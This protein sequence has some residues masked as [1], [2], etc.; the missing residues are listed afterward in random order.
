MSFALELVIGTSTDTEYLV[1]G[2]VNLYDSLDSRTALSFQLLIPASDNLPSVGQPVYLASSTSGST[3]YVFGG[4]LDSYTK[5]IVNPHVSSS[6]RYLH[7]N[8]QCVDF[9]QMIGKRLVYKNYPSSGLGDYES[10]PTTDT[11]TGDGSNRV[12]ELTY[13]LTTDPT[14][15]IDAIPASVG[16]YGVA[17]STKAFY[18]TPSSHILLSNTSN[19]AMATTD[20]LKA[21]YTGIKGIPAYDYQIIADIGAAFCDGEGI[22]FATYVSTGQQLEEL[23]CNFTPANV[24]INTI[25]N[26]TGRSWYIDPWKNLHYFARSENYSPWD[27][28]STSD[29][30]RSLTVR[31]SRDKYRNKEYVL[32]SYGMNP[33]EESFY[34]DG[35]NRTFTLSHAVYA[36]PVISINGYAASVGVLNVA[37]STK[38][39]YWMKESA[40]IVQN[41][42]NTA[43]AS[44][45]T[46]KVSYIGLYPVVAIAEDGAEIAARAAIEGNSGKYEA[47]TESN[48]TYTGLAANQYGASI[49]S[50][51]GRLLDTISFET[52]ESGLMAG[53]LIHISLTDYDIDDDYYITQVTARDVGMATLRYSVQAVSGSDRGG[54]VSFFRDLVLAGKA[55]YTEPYS[56]LIQT[57]LISARGDIKVIDSGV[58]ITSVSFTIYLV[59]DPGSVADTAYVV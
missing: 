57:V 13:P 51:Y 24:A 26:I 11:F 27:I 47:E 15:T 14:L 30:W 49:I 6:G 55:I 42:S 19:T 20:T 40:V 52:D 33:S 25:C 45:D 28:S 22:D 18:Y 4:T 58:T 39:F 7:L 34:G 10:V 32:G 16:V 38:A 31:K 36:A 29:N 2:S 5:T 9:T 56:N 41:S 3:C 54:W 8:C 43:L 59:D 23:N 1:P 12:F 48:K 17:T 21:I 44:T 50:K 35:L 37:T 46:L 53:Q